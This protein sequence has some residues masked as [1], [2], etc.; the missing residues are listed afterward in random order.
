MAVA[1]AVAAVRDISVFLS[2]R[3]GGRAPGG[4]DVPMTDAWRITCAIDQIW[5]I[6]PIG[7][8][9]WCSC[10]VVAARTAL[11]G[12]AKEV[13]GRGRYR[14]APEEGSMRET[15]RR[16]WLEKSVDACMISAY[17]HIGGRNVAAACVD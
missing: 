15:D 4:R 2:Q 13:K 9:L 5:R 8:V 10:W 6:Q 12:H 1:L 3:G 11:F 14:I 17:R 7:G 16:T